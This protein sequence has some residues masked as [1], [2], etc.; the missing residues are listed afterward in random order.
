F[1]P[2][3]RERAATGRSRAVPRVSAR[4]DPEARWVG[5]AA[6]GQPGLRVRLPGGPGRPR[7][8]VRPEPDDRL[9]Q[10]AVDPRRVPAVPPVWLGEGEGAGETPRVRAGPPLRAPR[11]GGLVGGRRR[12]G[13]AAAEAGRGR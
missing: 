9:P 7:A 5:R 1:D 4:A 6:R 10:P 3:L 2:R 13:P 11:P 8:P 12:R